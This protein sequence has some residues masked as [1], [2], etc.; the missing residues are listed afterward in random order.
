MIVLSAGYEG[1]EVRLSLN[2]LEILNNA[3]NEVC[4]GVQDLA[5]DG[6]FQTRLGW[7]RAA[8]RGLLDKVH[9]AYG[10][11]RSHYLSNLGSPPAGS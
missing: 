10:E 11:L 2:D 5:D 7:E 9:F 1:L 4:N 8:V 6:E 3:L